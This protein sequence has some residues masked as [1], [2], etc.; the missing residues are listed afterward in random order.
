MPVDQY[1]LSKTPNKHL[2]ES[3]ETI[4]GHM[5]HQRQGLRSIKKA[6]SKHKIVNTGRE[7]DKKEQDV[8]IKAMDI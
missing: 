5:Y 8:Y 3:E 2:L 6:A 1:S 4:T 7:T